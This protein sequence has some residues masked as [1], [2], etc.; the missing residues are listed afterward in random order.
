[1]F[2]SGLAVF[3]LGIFIGFSG[4]RFFDRDFLKGEVL[5]QE[6]E[7]VVSP[8]LTSTPT[9]SPSPTSTPTPSVTPTPTLTP[10]PKPT[11]IILV[12]GDLIPLFDEFSRIYNVDKEKLERIAYCESHFNRGVWA[13]PYAGMYQL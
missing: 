2:K 9:P 11:P 3:I 5:S 8:T 6:F 7:E 12:P 4:M 13:P 10:T 1:M